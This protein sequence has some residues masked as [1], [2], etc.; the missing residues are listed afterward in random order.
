MS[1]YSLLPEGIDESEGAEI[2]VT[3]AAVAYLGA[4]EYGVLEADPMLR[5]MAITVI[6]AVVGLDAVVKKKQEK[7]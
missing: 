5:M 6:G 7:L 2:I 3:L 1:L 4:V